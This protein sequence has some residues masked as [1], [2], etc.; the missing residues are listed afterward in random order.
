MQTGDDH[1]ICRIGYRVDGSSAVLY[2]DAA[3]CRVPPTGNKA[4]DKIVYC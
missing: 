1:R 4:P 3:G 2:I